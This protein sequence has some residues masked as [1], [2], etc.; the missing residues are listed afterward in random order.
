M[1]ISDERLDYLVR[2]IS[3]SLIAAKTVSG[4]DERV[5]AE[6]V[7]KGMVRYVQLNAKVD[8]M[9]RGKISSLRRQ[10][11]EGSAEWD[12]LYDKYYEEE[13]NQQ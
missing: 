12:V 7:R 3:A 1:Q 10:V 6:A 11:L 13:L 8:E 5:V 4:V 2:E 9:V